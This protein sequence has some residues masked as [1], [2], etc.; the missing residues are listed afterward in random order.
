MGITSLKESSLFRLKNSTYQFSLFQS[1]K[2]LPRWATIELVKSSVLSK[3]SMSHLLKT[4][5]RFIQHTRKIISRKMEYNWSNLRVKNNW[6]ESTDRSNLKWI[7]T[8]T[9]SI[10][11]FVISN[12][13]LRLIFP[14][15][16]VLKFTNLCK[17][18][19]IADKYLKINCF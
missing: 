17:N 13:K 12:E 14:E 1:N 6:D 16:L 10:P 2:R 15:K 5:Y 19:F 4:A 18:C 9:K 8:H 7:V 11:Y 3:Y